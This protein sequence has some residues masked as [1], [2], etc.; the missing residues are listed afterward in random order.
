MQK[1]DKVRVKGTKNIGT[2]TGIVYERV[3]SSTNKMF[4]VVS[5]ANTK[6]PLQ[7]GVQEL[8]KNLET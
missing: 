2:I 6:H 1:G 8:T 3:G 7:Y 4:C 5:F